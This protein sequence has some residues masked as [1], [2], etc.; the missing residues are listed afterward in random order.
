MRT[1][2]M[3][4]TKTVKGN[5]GINKRVAVGAIEVPIFDLHDFGITDYPADAVNGQGEPT[6]NDPKLNFVQAA[7]TAQ[8]KANARNA[9]KPGTAELKPGCRIDKTVEECL[10]VT[11]RTGDSLRLHRDFVQDFAAYLSTTKYKQ[12]VQ[13]LFVNLVRNRQALPL[14]TQAARDGL[15]KALQGFAESLDSDKL[16]QYQNLFETLEEAAVSAQINEDDFDL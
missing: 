15:L 9:L 16:Q 1:V 8:L 5:D 6:Y 2:T 12:A 3:R 10:E 11:A 7:L 4:V 14:A 13:A